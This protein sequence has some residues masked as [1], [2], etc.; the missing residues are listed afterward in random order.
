MYFYDFNFTTKVIDG[1]EFDFSIIVQSDTGY[2]DS[3]IESGIE[4]EKFS[5]VETATSKIIFLIGRNA[6]YNHEEFKD[7]FEDETNS[8]YKSSFTDYIKA[9]NEKVLLAKTFNLSNFISQEQTDFCIK[10]LVD[11]CKANG[12][13][14]MK[15]K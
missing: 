5:P 2:Y 1:V 4:T 11:F 12:I 3:G 14:E 15:T 13:E 7:D 9:T 10:E 6:W 8:I